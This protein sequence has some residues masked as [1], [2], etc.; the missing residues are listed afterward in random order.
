MSELQ[1]RAN[2]VLTTERSYV[3]RLYLVDQVRCVAMEIKVLG[4]FCQD[5]F[6]A[7]KQFVLVVIIY[8]YQKCHWYVEG[9]E[10]LVTGLI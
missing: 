6:G 10:Q 7:S 4:I 8:H 3:A 5:E 9:T 1:K 2:A